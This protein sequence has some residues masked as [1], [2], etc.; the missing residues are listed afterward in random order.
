MN[1]NNLPDDFDWKV[2]TELNDDLTN[3][4]KEGAESHYMLYGFSEGRY[5]KRINLNNKNVVLITSK[6]YVS[7]KKFSY[8]NKRSIYSKKERFDQTLETIFSVKINIPN[9]YIILFDNSQFDSDE[10]KILTMMVDKFINITDNNNLN[11]YTN[12]YEYKAFAEISQIL[13]FNDVFFKYVDKKSI[14]HFFKISGRYTIISSKFIYNNYDN[15]NNIFKKN[16]H[17]KD[18][19]YYYTCF[20]KLN[21]VILDEYFNHLKTLQENKHLYENNV[22][23]LEVILPKLLINEIKIVENLGINERLAVF[24]K[25]EII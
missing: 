2:Y 6:I 3:F 19:D 17:V 9:S 25:M 23:D 4:N 8:V 18:R 1:V 16:N 21:N 11:F 14:N 5:Y 20:Y 15:K 10:F 24:M 22:S 7:E 13:L 12:E